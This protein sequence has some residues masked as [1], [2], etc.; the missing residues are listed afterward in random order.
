MKKLFVIA[1]SVAIGLF[2]VMPVL[3]SPVQLSDKDMDTVVAGYVEENTLTLTDDA[4]GDFQGLSNVNDVDSAVSVQ[5][6]ATLGGYSVT[7]TNVAD[8][9][10][11]DKDVL[12]ELISTN[13]LT[14]SG[15]AQ[16]ELTALSNVNAIDSANAVQSNITVNSPY[17]VSE[18][19]ADVDNKDGDST[20]DIRSGN[21]L[22]LANY[23]QAAL[24]ALSNLNSVDSAVAVQSN[25]N[26]RGT[27]VENLNYA[28]VDNFNGDSGDVD[29]LSGLPHSLS[30]TGHAQE[31]LMAY[32]NV[33][34]VDSAV[35]VQL[36]TS[37][38]IEDSANNINDG[39]ATNNSTDL[40]NY[41]DRDNDLYIAGNGQAG[42][43]GI[44]NIN[45]VDSADLAQV[46]ISTF[47]GTIGMTD[48]NTVRTVLND[49]G[50]T[51]GTAWDRDTNTM[52]LT[53]NAQKGLISLHNENLVDSAA[54]TEGNYG[55]FG[56]NGFKTNTAYIT[57]KDKNS[58]IYASVN[59][60]ALSENAQQGLKAISNLNAV[61]SAAG[62]QIN[63]S[64]EV[65]TI[66]SDNLA[67]VTNNDGAS[68]DW[69]D[70]DNA[71]TIT[72]NAQ[73]NLNALSNMNTLDSASL[74]Q[75]NLAMLGAST[76]I[77]TNNADVLNTDGSADG[78]EWGISYN[79]LALSG[80]SQQGLIAESN[81]NEVDSATAVQTNITVEAETGTFSDLSSINIASVDNLDITTTGTLNGIRSYNELLLSG[82]S[83]RSLQALSNL[84]SVD[85]ANAAQTNI[86]ANGQTSIGPDYASELGPDSITVGPL[87][88]DTILLNYPQLTNLNT[89]AGESSDTI[90]S[91]NSATVTNTDGTAHWMDVLSGKIMN[92]LEFSDDTQRA[93]SALTN[94][95]TVDSA[96]AV[97]ANIVYAGGAGITS[98]NWASVLNDDGKTD[99]LGNTV[100]GGI[101]NDTNKLL[102]SGSS[103]RSLKALSNLNT[104]DS[105]NSV[106]TNI[107]VNALSG[108]QA[109]TAEVINKPRTIVIQR[110]PNPV[111]I[112]NISGDSQRSLSALSNLNTVD[113][114]NSVQTNYAVS[115]GNIGN[116]NDATVTNSNSD[117]KQGFT[118]DNSI[119]LQDNA[120]KELKAL[121][122]INSVDSANAVQVNVAAGI[123][124]TVSTNNAAVLNQDHDGTVT[125]ISGDLLQKDYLS[126]STD[127]QKLLSAISN[128]NTVDSANLVQF[129]IIKAGSGSP[130]G[131]N[132]AASVINKDANTANSTWL[133]QDN[134]IELRG[135]S[136]R[137]LSSLSNLNTVDSANLAQVN[138]GIVEGAGAANNGSNDAT[139]VSNTD[140][141]VLNGHCGNDQENFLGLYDDAQRSLSA[142][143]NLNTVDSANAVQANILTTSGDSSSTTAA[144]TASSINKDG[145]GKHLVQNNTLH[146]DPGA[147]REL[148]A[149]SNL[150][151]VDSANSVQMNVL[152]LSGS[153]VSGVTANTADVTNQ[154]G[155][156]RASWGADIITNN[157]L[158]LEDTNQMNLKALSNINAIDSASSVQI[159][160]ASVTGALAGLTNSNTAT[161]ENIDGNVSTA[162]S[163]PGSGYPESWATIDTTNELNISGKSQKEL[164]AMSN[165]NTV[166]SANSVQM[167]VM[168]LGAA[169]AVGAVTNTNTAAVTNID[170][171]AYDKATLK[172]STAVNTLTIKNQ[173]QSSMCGLSSINTV[174]SA[175]AVQMNFTLGG[176][177]VS[178]TNTAEV[179]NLDASKDGEEEH[180]REVLNSLGISGTS[181]ISMSTLSN[182]NSV[183]S[184]NAVQSNASKGS[185]V[186]SSNFAA[187][188]NGLSK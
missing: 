79:S 45:A 110:K 158:P 14:V 71:L 139:T 10:N 39:Y 134:K 57:N 104:V 111:N 112:L 72:D 145:K 167:N 93:L 20:V 56:E 124:S 146:L 92:R 135:D 60:M 130:S 13:T 181:Q 133:T 166:D 156:S 137:N 180:L 105:A 108:S 32:S 171:E 187:V 35:C 188:I 80:N 88:G 73:K 27:D 163:T 81:L 119:S 22:T 51:S 115:S 117:S 90:Y 186:T 179:Y 17:P 168:C 138:I 170:G 55:A 157:Y 106:Q 21:Y 89:G 174:D 66:T 169:D 175:N 28:D 6:H 129:N 114:A 16:M 103:Q 99:I 94:L 120:Q 78:Y 85:S 87:C 140:G 25:V 5:S 49:D 76:S 123:A 95:N 53:G 7:S 184:A 8:V 143:S 44:V 52:T 15:N 182:L 136:Q 30:I 116:N 177:S 69:T 64:H 91:S 118:Q 58:Y 148:S 173:A 128:I 144:N 46:N 121:S 97:Q 107:A 84:N 61:D 160:T 96:N 23:A 109:N 98:L 11:S 40:A 65:D 18:N 122:N 185:N 74:V 33:N 100:S 12:E 82:N 63:V 2:Q 68:R 26:I 77:S 183:D 3:A 165:L 24:Y 102:L 75:A 161:V 147:Q 113:S 36:N 159:N 149:M 162:T 9:D 47:T 155:D 150:N 34:A 178:N 31:N 172:K 42:T 176:S 59:R 132:T 152:L 62:V 41:M 126:L 29:T 101:S 131:V 48:S 50:A 4:Q 142:V 37:I 153:S 1:L 70:V 38:D 86:T 83:Q 54:T 67:V 43:N 154:D 141:D 164:C 125:V 151:S 127:A 19:R